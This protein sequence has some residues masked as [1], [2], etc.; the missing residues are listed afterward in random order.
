MKYVS[1][2]CVLRFLTSA[3]VGEGIAYSSGTN[4]GH[5]FSGPPVDQSL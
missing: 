2:I 5:I 4:L 1:V 3:T